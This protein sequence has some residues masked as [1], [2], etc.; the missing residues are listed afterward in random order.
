[1]TGLVR[2]FNGILPTVDPTAFI[3]ETAAVIGD[4]VIGA[5]SSIW[6]GCTVRGDVNEVRIGA[7]TNIQDGTVIHVAS[8]GQG[9]YIGDDITVGHMALLHACTLEDGCFIGMKAC[10]LDGAYVESRAMVAAGALVT[11]G[12]RVTSGFLW[13]GSPARPVR[14]LTERDLAVFPVLSHRYT[15]LAETYRKSCYG[16]GA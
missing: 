6:Y 3:A 7:R 12:K 9:T 14:E 1:M 2:A 5:N 11:P 8:E 13:A 4:V 10:I 15:D 16:S